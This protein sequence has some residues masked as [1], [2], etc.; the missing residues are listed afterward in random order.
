MVQILAASQAAS[1]LR[2]PQAFFL[3]TTGRRSMRSA[4]SR[5]LF[6]EPSARH[7]RRDRP[8]E[9]PA[10]GLL[11]DIQELIGAHVNAVA[12]IVSDDDSPI[13]WRGRIHR[14]LWAATRALVTE[15]YYRNSMVLIIFH[16]L[17]PFLPSYKDIVRTSQRYRQYP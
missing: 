4:A 8:H 12:E 1:S 10:P 5:I 11:Y 6:A 7:A 15:T 3:V 9:R 17:P 13:V 14:E 2:K 16:D